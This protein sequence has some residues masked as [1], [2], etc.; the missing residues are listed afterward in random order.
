[1]KEKIC[2]QCEFE[3]GSLNRFVPVPIS[4]DKRLDPRLS[5][6]AVGVVFQCRRTSAI[7]ARWRLGDRRHERPAVT[8][9]RRHVHVRDIRDS[10][11]ITRV[12]S[13]ARIPFSRSET[14]DRVDGH[15]A[16]VVR[17][18]SVR[19]WR[20]ATEAAGRTSRAT[21]RG[22]TW[23]LF[24]RGTVA[25]ERRLGLLGEWIPC[26]YRAGSVRQRVIAADPEAYHVPLRVDSIA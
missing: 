11:P 2:R 9:S 23:M 20:G 4:R 12:A 14:H 24:V 5:F 10:L 25:S 22:I 3:G 6:E 8:W 26:R 18:L 19:H 15:G 7:R 21:S 16:A 17:S 13:P 1:M